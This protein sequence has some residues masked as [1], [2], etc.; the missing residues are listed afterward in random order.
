MSKVSLR[1]HNSQQSNTCFPTA[2]HIFL[3][4]VVLKKL[5]NNPR[6]YKR[7]VC[8]H[9]CVR[10]NSCCWYAKLGEGGVM[11]LTLWGPWGYKLFPSP[12]A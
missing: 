10:V 12:S 5:K 6:K 1:I 3:E 9:V 2:K 8:V 7:I 11:E 4:D